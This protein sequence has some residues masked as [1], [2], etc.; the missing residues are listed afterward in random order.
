MGA[1][2]GK[3]LFPATALA[4]ACLAMALPAAAKPL[5]VVELF[6]SQ[7]CNSCPPA[8]AVLGDLVRRGGVVVL[9]YHVDYWDYLGWKDTLGNHANT[10]RQYDYAKAFGSGQVYTPQAVVNGRIDVNGASGSAI[11]GA[12]GKLAEAGEGL[13]VDVSVKEEGGALVVETG[14]AAGGPD[15]A[16]IVVVSFAPEKDVPI[17]RGENSGRTI[18]YWHAVTGW[19]TAGTW[20]G[21]PGR[22]EIPKGESSGGGLAVLLQAP[23]KGGTPGP[24]IGAATL[25]PAGS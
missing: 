22:I 21:K 11:N 5:G 3:R 8:D 19:H 1:T 20:Q 4:A 13:T 25:R 18:R 12:L 17:R 6:T 7:G 23:G 24:I 9:A 16:S 14:G 10:A 15:E 2:R